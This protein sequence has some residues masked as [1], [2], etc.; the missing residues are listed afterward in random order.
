MINTLLQI[1]ENGESYTVNKGEEDE[2]TVIRPPTKTSVQAAKLI[3][4]LA[5]RAGRDEG[6]INQLTAELEEVRA[7]L[8]EFENAAQV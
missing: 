3:K 4:E 1:L 6:F 7:K 8:K 2:H 5:N